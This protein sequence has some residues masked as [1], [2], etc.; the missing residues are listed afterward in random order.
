M[1]EI[2]T[3]ARPYAVATFQ[4]ASEEGRI[5][6]WSAMLEL[7]GT[8]VGDATMKGL[9]ANPRVRR[10]QLAA[11]II[12]VCAERL[13]A[14]GRNL[15]RVLAHNGRLGLVPAIAELFERERAR[16]RGRS[17]VEVSS[18]FELSESE[19][20]TITAALVK[21][22]GGAV[23]LAEKLDPTLIGGMVIRSGDLVIDASLRGR[24]DQF[25]LVLG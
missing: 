14:T 25:A 24:L 9:L 5:D 11:L 7:L 17:Q 6:D 23:D 22:L 18:A 15:V 20:A 16:T 3:L 13:S 10:E 12:D 4:Q 21:R 8:V 19:R 1:A 2:N